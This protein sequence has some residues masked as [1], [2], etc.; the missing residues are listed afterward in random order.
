MI[1]MDSLFN[2]F[3]NC[4]FVYSV[5]K[6]DSIHTFIFHT[7]TP[8]LN[9]AW[10]QLSPALSSFTSNYSSSLLGCVAATLAHVS[11][12]AFLLFSFVLLASPLSV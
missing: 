8:T 4:Y 7:F 12:P 6:V 9:I 3:I 11:N 10:W 2:Y 5:F 1:T